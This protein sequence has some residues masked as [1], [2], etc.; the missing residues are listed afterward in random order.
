MK[1]YYYISKE[2]VRQG[3]FPLDNLTSND[4]SQNTFVWCKGMEKWQRAKDVQDFAKIFINQSER[5]LKA[6]V[7]QD[8]SKDLENN[9]KG[10]ENLLQSELTSQM[11]I[12][13]DKETSDYIKRNAHAKTPIEQ[14]NNSTSGN[15]TPL[16]VIIFVLFLITAFFVFKF[17]FSTSTKE[18]E[19][20]TKVEIKDE[21][22]I[23][24]EKDINVDEQKKIKVFL[25]EIYKQGRANDLFKDQWI[26]T[27]CTKR[28][29][30]F[31]RDVSVD[32]SWG[33][34]IIGGWVRGS[35][36]KIK[37][38]SITSDESYYYVTIVPE[39]YTKDYASG[40]RIVRFVIYLIND[41]PVIDECI[42]TSNFS[43]KSNNNDNAIN[44]NNQ[45]EEISKNELEQLMHD[46]DIVNYQP[47][48]I[49]KNE[50]EQL[51]HDIDIISYQLEEISE[52]ELEQ[53][54]HG[55]DIINYQLEGL[56]NNK[57]E[58]VLKLEQS[59]NQIN[60]HYYYKSSMRKYGDKEAT[61]IKLSGSINKNGDF[62]LKGSFY[63]SDRV[64][65][66]KGNL[67]NDRLHAKCKNDNGSTME[68]KANCY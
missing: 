63:N 17:V 23:I 5:E 19:S 4:I 38:S 20:L 57:Y 1:F 64:E 52:N 7:N 42:W 21:L 60:G 28:M 56:V 34:W 24:T 50:L 27:H 16:Y 49:S 31:L 51:M 61:Y 33:S 13:I 41:I 66:W 10:K 25:S 65:I 12:K 54:M 39:E 43:Y 37:I 6:E 67:S 8:N 22:S 2:G 14:T 47:E 55:I 9:I 36:E 32:D 68:M 45:L 29:Q 3:P 26:Y 18:I 35:N 59:G 15:K 46:I 11:G 48:E 53:L 44:N 30:Q 58:V 40:K 62:R